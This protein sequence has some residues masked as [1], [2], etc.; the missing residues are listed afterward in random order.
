[1]HQDCRGLALTAANAEAARHFDATIEAYLGFKA[2]TGDHLK[3][4]FAADPAMAMAQIVKGCFMHLFATRRLDGKARAAATSAHESIRERGA[5]ERERAHLAAL[6]AWCAGDFAGAAKVWETILA[7]HPRDA[8][9]LRLAHYMHFYLGDD[10]NL[11]DSIH[12]VL[13]A[14][15]ETV[16]GY[17]YVLG[18]KAFGCEEA[19]DYTAAEAAGRE[20]VERNPGDLWA[21]HGVAHVLEMQARA[22]EGVAW[23]RRAPEA[24]ADTN[25]FQNHVWWHLSLF[26][27][28]LGERDAVFDLYDSRIRAEPSEEY[29]DITNAA[30]LLWRLEDEDA[31]IGD[32]WDEL[33]DLAAARESD[34][35][36]AFADAHYVMCLA[37]AGRHEEGEHY[38]AAWTAH[39]AAYP[40]QT[41]SPVTADIGVPLA[42]A[43]L[44]YRAGRFGRVVELLMP[45]RYGLI[46]LGGSHAQRDVWERMLIEAAIRGGEVE[47][48]RLLLSERGGRRPDGPWT[49]AA[50]ARTLEG[51]GDPT[52]A[53]DARKRVAALRAA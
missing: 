10:A 5:T 3:A 52:G 25:P 8:L 40:E 9:A 44:E 29:L 53:E 19:G 37:A 2:D 12:R 20:A 42:R 6:D 27:L 47:T 45:A 50:W 17:G 32:R 33:A 34:H 35:V 14:W 49:C 51:L 21:V 41:E 4:C 36:L 7:A 30:S 38:L 31:D 39:A 43:I 48:A 22:R 24:W 28:E 16:P 26:H 1:M 11:R 18:M 13:W 23:V 46:R 15:D